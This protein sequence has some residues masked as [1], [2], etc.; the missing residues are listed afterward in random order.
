M[1]N[2]KIAKIF[3]EIADFLEM[4][5]I[6]FRPQAYRRA[7]LVLNDFEEDVQEIY[8]RGGKKALDK[9]VSGIGE[10]LA[11]KI[12]EYLLTNKIKYL[13]YLRKRTPLDMEKLNAVEGLGPK[14]L[15]VLYVKLGIA[16]IEDLEKAARS[17][18]IAPLF[19]FGK[20]IEQN[21]LESLSF[22][23]KSKGRFLLGEM[24]T[25][26]ED[27]KIKLKSLKE[28]ERIDVAGSIRRGRETVGDVD[29]L[30]QAKESKKI[31]DFF[32]SLPGVIKIWGKG[33]TRSSIKMEEGLDI[34]L[35][36]VNKE[37]YGSALQYFTGSKDHNIATRKL[38][39][40][41]G[42][43]LSEYG[44]FKGEKQIAG[45]KEEDVYNLLGLPFIPPELRENNGEIEAGLNNNLPSLVEQENIKGDLHCHST[46]SE[47][48]H[49]I[50]EMAEVAIHLG[51]EYLGITDHAQMM[52]MQN[53]L[54]EKRLLEQ[55][56][57][58][59]K[60][61]EGFKNK[62][63][64]FRI[65]KSIEA[66][67][68]KDGSLDMSDEV[69]SKLDYVLA[70]VHSNLKM[71]GA[72]MTERII[73]AIENP[74]VKMIAHL[75]G[76]KIKKR[77]EYDLDFDK[78]FKSAKDSNVVLE[79]NAQP[80]R[81]DIRDVRIREAKEHGVKMS[82]NTDAHLKRS[83]YLMSLG[84]SQARRGWAEPEDI[85]NTLSLVKLL[86]FFKNNG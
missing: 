1:I 50:S 78:I 31:M 3:F 12:E 15:K 84:V 48:K 49:S 9:E 18:E 25:M 6:P 79:I 39:I 54:D 74:Y 69:L 59:D 85:I 58:I 38:A 62:K 7:A 83:L 64:N 86:N 40:K 20:K 16:T 29:F 34:D 44:L 71:E 68:L 32:V 80:I 22:F 37:S 43:K 35:R 82:I 46:W 33:E 10:S 27:I 5:D 23:E 11:K 26:V 8:N 4:E 56:K 28:V 81:L 24:W 53:G 75:T 13:E 67:I 47:G 72:E 17:G 41:K 57:E 14:R 65:L 36:I 21:I 76:R 2:K 60:L 51:Y 70:G 55:T 42:L 77:N 63:I 52:K 66:N 30:V 45:E 73:K 19:G 61:N